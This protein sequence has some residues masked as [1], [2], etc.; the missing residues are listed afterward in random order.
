MD[1]FAFASKSE[2]QGMVLTEAM[3]AGVP[4]VALDAPGARELVSDGRNG[5]L[6]ECTATVAEFCAGLEWVA[7]LSDDARRRLVREAKK[8]AADFSMTR[9]AERALTLYRELRHGAFV[10]RRDEY[11]S[12]AAVRRMIATEW[13]LLKGTASAAG[14]ALHLHE[15]GSE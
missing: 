14:A 4:V 10:G 3:A 11:K 6:L 15:P 1:V 9:C 7:E 12:W 8:T 5:R 2:T 13:D